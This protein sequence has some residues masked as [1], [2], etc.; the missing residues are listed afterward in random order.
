MKRVWTAA[1]DAQESDPA[2]GVA[3]VV[4]MHACQ[5]SGAAVVASGAVSEVVRI[6]VVVVAAAAA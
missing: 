3:G 2:S 1:V 5:Q 6:V 4:R